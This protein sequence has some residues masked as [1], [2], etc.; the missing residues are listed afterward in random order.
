MKNR[1]WKYPFPTFSDSMFDKNKDGKL[2]VFET[3]FRDAHIEEINRNTTK[4]PSKKKRDYVVTENRFKNTIENNDSTN[5]D[6]TTS[7]I[8]ELIFVLLAVAVLIFGFVLVLSAES[9]MFFKAVIMFCSATIAIAL[10]KFADI[11]R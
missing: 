4:H 7:I 11:Y 2:D 3:A 1:S 5:S 6:T 9:S 8:F 10:L